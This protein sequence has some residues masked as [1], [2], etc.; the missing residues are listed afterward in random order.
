LAAPTRDLAPEGELIT[1]LRH[2]QLIKE[3]LE[4]LARARQATDQRVPHEMLLLD[5]YDTLRPLDA[6]TGATT[7]DDVLGIIFSTFCVGK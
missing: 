3:S 7:T 6:I 1:N 4:A 5:L 2:Q